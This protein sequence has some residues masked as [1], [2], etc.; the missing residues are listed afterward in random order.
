MKNKESKGR[1]FRNGDFI[2]KE[3]VNINVSLYQLGYSK[4][5]LW[6]RIRSQRERRGESG[7]KSTLM[8]IKKM[9]KI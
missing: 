2:F 3:K 8:E 9:A 6:I 4:C 7:I 5:R 1:R